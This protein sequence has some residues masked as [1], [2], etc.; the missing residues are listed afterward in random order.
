MSQALAL[1]ATAAVAVTFSLRFSTNS[2]ER[3]DL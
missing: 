1:M 2:K 3:K